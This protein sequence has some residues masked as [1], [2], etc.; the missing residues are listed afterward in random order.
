MDLKDLA[1]IIGKQIK[2]FTKKLSLTKQSHPEKECENLED[3]PL[4]EYREG[5]F[6]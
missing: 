5:V 4:Y 6:L 1:F 2:N 3:H